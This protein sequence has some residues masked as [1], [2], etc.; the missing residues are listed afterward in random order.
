MIFKNASMAPLVLKDAFV[1]ASAVD[2]LFALVFE[3]LVWVLAV[4]LETLH[5]ALFWALGWP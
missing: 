1:D 3:I 2:V 5:K 4:A